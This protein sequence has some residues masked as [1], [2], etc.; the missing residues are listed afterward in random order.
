MGTLQELLK[1]NIHPHEYICEGI[2]PNDDD[3]NPYQDITITPS[4][5]TADNSTYVV[6]IDYSGSWSG[7]TSC[8]VTLTDVRGTTYTFNETFF[9]S[10]ITT[11]AFTN[12]TS[13]LFSFLT[14]VQQICKR[15]D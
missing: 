10:K 4:D 8:S 15:G 9:N 2:D 5:F 6:T 11:L 3:T 13:M 1:Y 7:L 12:L 14:R